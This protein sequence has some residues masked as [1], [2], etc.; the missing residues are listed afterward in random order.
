MRRG[1]REERARRLSTKPGVGER[2]RRTKSPHAE[3]RHQKGMSRHEADR[4]EDL[5]EERLGIPRERPEKPTPRRAVR[6]ETF[7]C[8]VDRSLQNRRRVVIERMGDGE[9]G[10]RPPQP[11]IAEVQPAHEWGNERHRM[12][13]RA[14]VVAETRKRQ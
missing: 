7:G 5:V 9:W 3:A 1:P 10:V 4:A 14:N 2:R 6:A 8:R 12:N 13:G 11:A